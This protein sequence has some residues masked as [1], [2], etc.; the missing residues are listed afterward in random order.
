MNRAEAAALLTYATVVDQ[1]TIGDEDVEVWQDLLS[2]VELCEAMA[3]A[4]EHFLTSDRR[5]SPVHIETWTKAWRKRVLEGFTEK[6]PT[7]DPND[8]RAYVEDLRR[9]RLNALNVARTEAF[10][11]PLK[12]LE[13]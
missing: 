11:V 1:R 10:G 9:Q 6:S 8:H 3:A 12:V 2:H 5:L 13:Q 4:K 7:C